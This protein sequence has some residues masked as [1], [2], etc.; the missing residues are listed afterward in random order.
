VKHDGGAPPK[1]FLRNGAGDF[2]GRFELYRLPG[3]NPNFLAIGGITS[4]SG[5]AF[6]DREDANAGQG[7]TRFPLQ[8]IAERVRE[9]RQ[10][11]PLQTLPCSSF[12]S[13]SQ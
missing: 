7:D 3:G 9:Y 11:S 2:L 12:F 6:L 4:R 10:K 1:V 5:G 8:A 13:H